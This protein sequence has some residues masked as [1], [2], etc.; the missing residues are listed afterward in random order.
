[1]M[2][3][4]RFGK[5]WR[6]CRSCCEFWNSKPIFA[7][8]AS[9]LVLSATRACHPLRPRSRGS[10]CRRLEPMAESH[11][12]LRGLGDAVF[13]DAELASFPS[14]Q[15][16]CRPVSSGVLKPCTRPQ[17]CEDPNL[18]GA[19]SH[20]RT[21]SQISARRVPHG[22]GNKAPM[23]QRLASQDSD[24]VTPAAYHM[25]IAS[26]MPCEVVEFRV[27]LLWLPIPKA[28]VRCPKASEQLA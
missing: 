11:T 19:S 1:M 10:S 18:T 23:S 7:L 15:V 8:F 24:I 26:A 13:R 21:F 20:L 6:G 16:V 12:F 4:C 25:I 28:S 27:P 2:L 17:S 5:W 14:F 3:P 9:Q 22:I